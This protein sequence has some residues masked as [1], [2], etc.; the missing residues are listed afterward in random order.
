MLVSPEDF[1]RRLEIVRAAAAGPRE[2]VYGPASVTWRVNREAAIFLGAGR[3]LLLQLAHPWVAARRSPRP[4]GCI[5][6]MLP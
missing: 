1:E 2:G 5:D 3:A 4:G 6:A